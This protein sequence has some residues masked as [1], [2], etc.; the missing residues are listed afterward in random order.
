M[1]TLNKQYRYPCQQGSILLLFASIS[2]LLIAF[3]G[4]TIYSGL[5][6]FVLQDLQRVSMNAAMV[7]AASYYSTVGSNGKPTANGTNAIN[8]SNS[9]FNSLKNGTSL[10]G[11]SPTITVTNNDANDSIT[12]STTATLGSSLMAPI[13]IKN[14]EIKAESTARALKYEP[15]KF[16]GALRI[17]P[18]GS[19]ISTYSQTLNLTFP[20]IDGP[21][22]DL[23]IEQDATLQQGYIVEACDSTSCY[24]LMAAA[25]PIGSSQLLPVAGGEQAL[26]GSAVFDLNKAGVRKG[27]KI[28]ITHANNFDIYNTGTLQPPPT[29]ATPLEIRKI[30]LFGYSGTCANSTTCSIP[31]GFSPV[32]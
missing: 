26:Y 22:N 25:T 6:T 12:V 23:Y 17:L 13:G 4:I 19:D 27:S 21:G 31:A 5:Q 2:V 3:M 1:N 32:E 7:G 20:L 24:N 14:I 11:F 18:D 16:T 29:V 8:I 15:T 9:T 28:R 30:M 10:N